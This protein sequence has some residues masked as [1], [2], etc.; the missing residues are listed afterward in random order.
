VRRGSED[1]TVYQL[2][3]ESILNLEELSKG[4]KNS[5]CTIVSNDNSTQIFS[6]SVENL[7]DIENVRVV[8]QH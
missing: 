3:V 8:P 6:I 2:G 5:S 4:Q 7:K 1:G